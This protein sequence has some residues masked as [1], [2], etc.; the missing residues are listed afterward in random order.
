ME[1]RSNN[2]TEESVTVHLTR[3]EGKMDVITEKLNRQD[4]DLASVRQRQHELANA[5]QGVVG[6]PDKLAVLEARVTAHGVKLDVHDAAANERKGMALASK[7]IYALLG[8][9][10]STVLGLVGLSLSMFGE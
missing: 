7:W 9:L 5:V 6:L 8:G 2:M 3:I 4:L 1:L 10:V